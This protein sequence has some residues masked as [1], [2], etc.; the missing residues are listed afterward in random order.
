MKKILLFLRDVIEL[1]IPIISF[2]FL[3]IAFI[4]Q[5]FFRYVVN[6]PLTW[7]QDIIVVGFCWTVILGA[8]YTMRRKGQVSFTMLYDQYPPKVAAWARLAGNVLIIVTFAVL[9]I[10]S[11]NYA[12][13]VSFQKTAALRIN[14]FWI[15]IPFTYFL[16]S[17]I[18]YTIEPVIEDGKII[19]GKL[20]D[21][22]ERKMDQLMKEVK[23]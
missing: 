14:Y 21:S 17:I 1:Y 3:F 11:V 12:I 7:T 9:V 8:C 2:T 6:R 20:D 10:P 15:F 19:T 5:V 23:A 13:F 4:L 16:L 18:G 22:A